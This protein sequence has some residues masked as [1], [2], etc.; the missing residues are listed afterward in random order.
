VVSFQKSPGNPDFPG[1]A[2][3]ICNQFRDVGPPKQQVIFEV[4]TVYAPLQTIVIFMSFPSFFILNC[5]FAIGRWLT[6][7]I[8]RDVPLF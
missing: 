7:I 2:K 8:T 6:T 3:A 1:D 4:P 5:F